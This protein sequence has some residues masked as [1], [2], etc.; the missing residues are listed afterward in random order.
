MNRPLAFEEDRSAGGRDLPRVLAVGAQAGT[1]TSDLE[2]DALHQDD[3]RRAQSIGSSAFAVCLSTSVDYSKQGQRLP[4]AFALASWRCIAQRPACQARHDSRRWLL[5]PPLRDVQQGKEHSTM[6]TQ[7]P[8]PPIPQP[9]PEPP[10]TPKQNPNPKP[11]PERGM[12]PP[13]KKQ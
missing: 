8:E 7:I 10:P 4:R 6:S 13:S 5:I 1:Q 3:L 12:P 2:R 9:I 11:K